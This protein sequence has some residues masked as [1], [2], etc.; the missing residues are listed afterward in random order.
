MARYMSILFAIPCVHLL[1]DPSIPN[2]MLIAAA[3]AI[4]AGWIE[5]QHNLF[6]TG[7]GFCLALAASLSIALFN[8]VVKRAQLRLGNSVC[9]I[10]RY[11]V[12]M[13]AVQLFPVAVISG[14]WSELSKVYFL[15]SPGFWLLTAACS[16][17][18]LLLAVILHLQ[19]RYAS[20][21]LSI[22]ANSARVSSIKVSGYMRLMSLFIV[23]IA[24]DY[25]GPLCRWTD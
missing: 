1:L 2:G 13:A 22:L 12:P 21:L 11:I 5:Q 6:F 4:L 20:P 23:G 14:E 9:R 18:G 16:G 24:N 10:L 8:T 17:I 19:I 7:V 3:M 15:Y 25:S